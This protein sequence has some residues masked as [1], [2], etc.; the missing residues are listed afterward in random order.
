MLGCGDDPAREDG[1]SVRVSE[2][3][4]KSH[5]IAVSPTTATFVELAE[6]VARAMPVA[7]PTRLR[8]VHAGAAIDGTN[9]FVLCCPLGYVTDSAIRS[10]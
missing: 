9:T 6:L 4:G 1:G 10:I 3:S 5:E 2:L 7:D 8:F